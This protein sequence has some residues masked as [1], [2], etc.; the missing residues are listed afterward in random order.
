MKKYLLSLGMLPVLAGCAM[1]Q[2]LIPSTTPP[3]PEPL[4]AA[5]VAVLPAG[6]PESVVM[7][8]AQGCYLY[9]IEVTTPPSGFPLRDASGQPICAPR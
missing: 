9:S 3:E 2:P 8:D 6:A 7:R 5:V 1:I 4:P